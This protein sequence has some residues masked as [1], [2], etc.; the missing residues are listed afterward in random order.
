MPGEVVLFT[1]PDKDGIFR[2]TGPAPL[3][4]KLAVACGDAG[5]VYNISTGTAPTAA[6]FRRRRRHLQVEHNCLRRP[7]PTAFELDA[8]LCEAEQRSGNPVPAV[9]LRQ[10]RAVI[11]GYVLDKDQQG[12][13]VRRS[14]PMALAAAAAL[15]MGRQVSTRST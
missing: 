9:E 10:A 12:V 15:W 2:L 13:Q 7:G 3:Q 5:C 4:T 14:V 8:C 11:S 6:A 1:R